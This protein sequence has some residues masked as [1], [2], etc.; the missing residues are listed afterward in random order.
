MKKAL[1]QIRERAAKAKQAKVERASIPYEPFLLENLKDL[2]FAAEYLAHA[3]DGT[4][5]EEFE[6]FYS[7]LENIVKAQGIEN[8]AEKMDSSRDT[9]YKM[10]KH[11]NATHRTLARLLDAVG[12]TLSIS[13]KQ[14][15]GVKRAK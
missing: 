6:I 10:F 2:D 9:L 4:D 11:Q 14:P 13:V 3:V 15:M 5:D 1:R 7:A 8:V 12:L